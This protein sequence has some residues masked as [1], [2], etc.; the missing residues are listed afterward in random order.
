M[1]SDAGLGSD[2]CAPSHLVGDIPSWV[3]AEVPAEGRVG[4]DPFLMSVGMFF[5]FFSLWICVSCQ[6][7]WLSLLGGTQTYLLRKRYNMVTG[8]L[9]VVPVEIFYNKEIFMHHVIKICQ[10]NEYKLYQESNEC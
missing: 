7:G 9:E 1:W 5:F 4:F 6:G 10:K 8:Y 2:F 3:L